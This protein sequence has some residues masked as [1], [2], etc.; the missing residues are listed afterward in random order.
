[1]TV[2]TL[3][4]TDDHAPLGERLI[5]L[6]AVRTVLV[7]VVMTAALFDPRGAGREGVLLA[8]CAGFA[9]AS[10]GLELCRK[11]ARARVLPI[12]GSML[13]VDVLFLGGV[14]VST[15][16]PQSRLTFLIYLHLVAVTLLLSFRTG[17]KLALW[18]S[19]VL[20]VG[21]YTRSAGLVD[22]PEALARLG[23]SGVELT[24]SAVIASIGFWLVAIVTAALSSL[25]ERELRRGKVQLRV[26]AGMG[27]TM[28]SATSTD[29]LL[30]ALTLAVEE[31]FG[32]GRSVALALDGD[33]LR[34]AMRR[35]G[36]TTIARPGVAMVDAVVER[37]W[38]HRQPVL[39]RTL[40]DTDDATLDALLP[41]AHNVVVVPL[42]AEGQRIGAL[43]VEHGG[44]ART[45]VRAR[46][47][48]MLEQYAVHAAL[49]LRNLWLL[50]E[51]R[52]LA[53]TD[54]L[55]G[56]A[57]RRT[58]QET[59][60]REV[61]RAERTEVP[62]SVV[63]LDIDH[64]KAVNDVHGHQAGDL[65]LQAVGGVLGRGLRASDL[66][67]RYGGEEFCLVL[68]DC[69]IDEA[70][71]IAERVRQ[72]VATCGSPVPVTISC[73]VASLPSNAASA[74]ALIEAADEALYESKRN[75]RNRTTRSQA[76]RRRRRRSGAA[77]LVA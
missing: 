69:E 24:R 57:N 32:F 34:V 59:L 9:M 41:F 39:V 70:E 3:V 40:D 26:L 38:V 51:V 13:F 4:A 36:T 63:L 55:T 47:V 14:L 2:G 27:A 11:V 28:E 7:L 22:P 49:E 21:H 6:Q 29:E 50:A 20:F 66:A 68:P 5:A 35:D 75:G 45:R 74:T 62:L 17:L 60:E 77:T 54:G 19:L 44:S 76:G 58:L 64:F 10:V 48:A 37:A 30:E 56:L 43:A 16:G 23:E 71:L 73:G 67:A 61:A 18:H 42:V 65:V 31:G 12:V 15:G 53:T 25:S 1:M 33:E 8:L 46:L 72:A 52:R